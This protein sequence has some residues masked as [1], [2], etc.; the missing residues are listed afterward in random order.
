MILPRLAAAPVLA[1]ALSANARAATTPELFQKMKTEYSLARYS[2]ALETLQSLEAE[3]A[4]PEN[5]RYRLQVEPALAFYRGAILASLGRAAEAKES[6]LRYL[7]IEPRAS[8][9]PGL[10]GS[11]VLKAFD[12][13]R[14]ERAASHAEPSAGGSLSQAYQR[15]RVTS[16]PETG[17]SWMDGPVKYIMS[18]EEMEAFSRLSTA[19]SRAEFIENFWRSRDPR[20]EARDNTFR[21]EFERRV[22]FADRFF[23]DGER[24]GSLTDRGIVFILL[25]PPTYV[26][27]KPLNTEDASQ[28][29]DKGIGLLT[30]RLNE[31]FGGPKA[32]NP[33]TLAGE[34]NWRE[35]WHY[36]K[37]LLP[38]SVPY[39]QVDFE[40]LT[41][42]GYGEHVLQREPST[43]AA[44]DAARRKAQGPSF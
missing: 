39:Q 6:F 8:V 20:P 27:R 7:E 22:A 36:R 23:R 31:N 13:A 5:E 43:T 34:Q 41:K 12:Q 38:A 3:S 9:D 11:A 40:F 26:G 19:Q 44:M 33:G 16:D 21:F 18:Q 29:S 37:E 25:G 42:K 30:S 17:D 1:L 4:R 14:R 32:Y 24:R 10:Y 2:R 28:P 35:I 15:F